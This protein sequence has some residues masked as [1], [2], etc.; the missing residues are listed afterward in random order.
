MAIREQ[1]VSGLLFYGSNAAG[2]KKEEGASAADYRGEYT[3]A[4]E[5]APPFLYAETLRWW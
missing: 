5:C 3:G 4:A 2:E 1:A